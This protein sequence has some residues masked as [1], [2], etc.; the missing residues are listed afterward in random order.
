M[1]SFA[2]REQVIQSASKAIVYQGNGDNRIMSK[3]K[4]VS[5]GFDLSSSDVEY[6]DFDSE[7]SLLDWDII[8]F[9][10]DISRFL[11]YADTY[12]GKPS[13]TDSKSFRLKNRCEHWFREIA[14][15]VNAGKCVI[16]FL[17]DLQEVY[18]ATGDKTYSGTGKNRQ[19]TR[20]VSAYDNYQCIPADLEPVSRKGRGIKLAPNNSSVI[21]SYWSEFESSSEY[22]VVLK[23][24]L[25][26]VLL[27][28]HGDKVVGAIFK[29]G[30]QGGAM[31]VLP[32]MDFSP[33]SFFEEVGTAD[34]FEEVWSDLAEQ[35]SA[36]L[37][38]CVS[39]LSSALRSE[40]E[41]T[42]EPD[43]ASSSAYSLDKELQLIS[44]LSKIEDKIADLQL[45]KNKALSDL[46]DAGRLRGLL[47]ETGKSLELAIID[48]LKILG[49]KAE[50]Y[51]DGNSEFDA[52]FESDE[53]RL[54]G[55]AEGKDNKAINVTKLRQLALNIH[56]DL[57]REDVA[58]PAKG[59]LFGNPYRLTPVEEREDPFTDKCKTAA[60]TSSTAL[61]FTPD[62]FVVVRY[63]SNH[64]DAAYAKKC[65]EV[66]S[67]TIGRVIFPE[68]PL[69]GRDQE[70]ISDQLGV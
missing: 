28:K 52:V 34:G 70:K 6:L 18:I 47:Y 41:H 13:L 43:W 49:F 29:S 15:S 25:S 26:A 57:E 55:E 24:G 51:S 17:S 12:K 14:D 50:N 66:I 21:A 20:I 54:I 9:R 10:P 31:V 1:A 36:R 30:S 59:V 42:P 46:R 63:L 53:G 8:L 48:A 19:T 60:A 37:V 65:R 2:R 35:F 61:V 16:V 4:I 39:S 23:D 44:G 27:T 45:K 32:D 67:S 33:E 11:D 40:G 38:K 22:K 3:K 69:K 5:V 7:Q 58:L 64:R 56:E 68:I 62:L